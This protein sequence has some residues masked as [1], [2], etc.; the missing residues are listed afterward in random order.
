MKR[1]LSFLRQPA[2]SDSLF[3]MFECMVDRAF[4]RT[5]GNHVLE[6]KA[7]PTALSKDVYTAVSQIRLASKP[8]ARN[9]A[10]TP[11]CEAF[12]AQ[13]HP[14]VSLVSLFNLNL[15]ILILSRFLAST[16]L[17]NR[18][19]TATYI[20]SFKFDDVFTQHGSLFQELTS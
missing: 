3:P 4:S 17:L 11:D 19:S 7:T 1:S 16:R 8:Y 5:G 6:M 12:V 14:I 2:V 18:F 10:S 13:V 15:R 9:I 20:Y